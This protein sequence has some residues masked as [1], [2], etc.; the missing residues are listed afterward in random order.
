MN[1]FGFN[2][3]FFP[4]YLISAI[5]LTLLWIK[6]ETTYSFRAGLALFFSSKVWMTKSMLIDIQ[7]SIVIILGV[8]FFL[9]PL[10][11]WFFDNG[12]VLFREILL[13]ISSGNWS[14]Q[15]PR[16]YEGIMA[17]MVTMLSID[18]ASYI[19]HR[20]MHSN[21][22]LRKIHAIHHSASE[23]NFFTTYR[24]H[25]L[26][27]LILNTARTVAAA[28]GLSIFHWF[29]KS[30]TPVITYQGIGIGFFVYMFTVNLHHSHIPVRYPQFLRYILISPHVHHIHHSIDQRHKN[31]NFGV[32]FSFWD[33]IFG[34]YYDG[35]IKLN[36]LCFGIENLKEK[37]SL[38]HSL[39]LI[40]K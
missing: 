22:L 39:Y 21:N 5:I 8:G 13:K 4:P 17:T 3:I 27:P 29:F 36:E 35:P 6:L 37:I 14:L 34:S 18:F 25:L 26:E 30:Q 2:S 23:L 31:K 12:L 20:W 11:A 9:G 33:R 15:L 38:K 19:I 32:V 24:Q 1:Y 10:E 40:G 28:L 7:F 16:L